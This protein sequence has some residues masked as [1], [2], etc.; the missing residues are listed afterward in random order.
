[1]SPTS[2]DSREQMMFVAALWRFQHFY[3][4]RHHHHHHGR[5]PSSPSSLSAS[6]LSLEHF[7]SACAKCA[8]PMP[9]MVAV[10]VSCAPTQGAD[11]THK[12][13]GNVSTNRKQ[14]SMRSA[15]QLRLHAPRPTWENDCDSTRQ[16]YRCDAGHTKGRVRATRR[17]AQT[18]RGHDEA[19]PTHL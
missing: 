6:S 13:G 16:H 18:R 9:A 3:R 15:T 2:C 4:C 8:S 19:Q 10:R 11:G 7:S 12:H 14:R 5:L 1:M 17:K